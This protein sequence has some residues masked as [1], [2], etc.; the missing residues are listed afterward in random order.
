[1]ASWEIRRLESGEQEVLFRQTRDAAPFRC[2]LVAA[3]TPTRLI[4][5]WIL[6]RGE[7]DP[8]DVVVDQDGRPYQL[9]PDQRA[10]A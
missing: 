6:T 5:E 1:M 7:A 10:V 8:G 9:L 2:G 4:L 3:D